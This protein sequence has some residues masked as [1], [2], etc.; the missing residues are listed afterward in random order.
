[1]YTVHID[2]DTTRHVSN[3]CH[4]AFMWLLYAAGFVNF[5]S[6]ALNLHRVRFS[7]SLS[8]SLITLPTLYLP[9][10]PFSSSNSHLHLSVLLPFNPVYRQDMPQRLPLSDI[11]GG[12]T[13]GTVSSLRRWCHLSF[14]AF[15]WLILVPICICKL[16]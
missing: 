16:N 1:M 14:V 6:I 3:L 2:T 12:I 15:V 5:V 7:L 8:L 9:L 4:V 11:I 13:W 10:S